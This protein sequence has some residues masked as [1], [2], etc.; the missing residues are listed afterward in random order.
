MAEGGNGSY[1]GGSGRL[2]HFSRKEEREE[3]IDTHC[4]ILS[5][6]IESDM[7]E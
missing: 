3:H 5:K 4:M 1:L 6:Y 7:A 2:S